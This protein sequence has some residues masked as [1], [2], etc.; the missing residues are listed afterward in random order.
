MSTFY[1]D[2]ETSRE[3]EL[4]E[5]LEMITTPSSRLSDELAQTSI[6]QAITIIRFSRPSK[7]DESLQNMLL[8]GGS[9]SQDNKKPESPRGG[10]RSGIESKEPAGSSGLSPTA[11]PGQPRATKRSHSVGGGETLEAIWDIT[12]SG[13]LSSA[14]F[15]NVGDD[16]NTWLLNNRDFNNRPPCP[17]CGKKPRTS[18][19]GPT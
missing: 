14:E 7:Q 11:E 15:I 4:S 3:Q 8:L 9:T 18:Q 19:P 2:F 17:N 5:D 12:T 6:R 13:S 16:A 10:A 1:S